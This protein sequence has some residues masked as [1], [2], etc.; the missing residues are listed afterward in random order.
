[1]DGWV[2]NWMD[3]WIVRW[4]MDRKA[5]RQANRTSDR[6]SLI[7]VTFSSSTLLMFGAGLFSVGLSCA[8]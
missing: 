4:M 1:M 5:G 6:V 3:G 8:L 2:D 7:H